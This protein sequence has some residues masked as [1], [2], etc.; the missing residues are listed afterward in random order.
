M[1]PL[2]NVKEEIRILGIDACNPGV[3][4]GAI[5]RGGLYLDGVIAFSKKNSSS[6]LA[7]EITETKYFPEL[8]IIMVHDPNGSLNSPAIRRIT[9]LP[10]ID[11]PIVAN[12]R[13][14]VARPVGPRQYRRRDQV[15]LDPVMLRRILEL[16]EGRG[17]L[18]EPVRIAHLLSKLHVFGRHWQDKR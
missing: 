15:G 14:K 2:G 6:A 3:T 8:R 18:P 9:Q 10:L 17:R 7:Y 16:T 5:V 11:V 12:N 1:K 13:A 4:V